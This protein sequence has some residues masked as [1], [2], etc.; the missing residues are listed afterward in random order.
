[1]RPTNHAQADQK[2]YF[3]MQCC[4]SF[5]FAEMNIFAWWAKIVAVGSYSR[6]I[7]LPRKNYGQAFG[8]KTCIIRPSLQINYDADFFHL[9]WTHEEISSL[10]VSAV[11]ITGLCN[12]HKKNNKNNFKKIINERTMRDCRRG[13]L[14]NLFISTATCL[15][16]PIEGLKQSHFHNKFVFQY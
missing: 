5:P 6:I 7:L 9:E 8:K 15:M 4:E 16:R 3:T 13:Y 12:Q 11:F 2:L 10:H 1:M 14:Q